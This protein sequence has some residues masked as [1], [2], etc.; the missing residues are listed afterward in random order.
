MPTTGK[1]VVRADISSRIGA[2][3]VMRCLALAQ[4]WQAEGGRTTFVCSELP[5]EFDDRL[6]PEC[7]DVVMTCARIDDEYIPG[8]E[9]PPRTIVH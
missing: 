7:C 3:H 1:L 8:A 5:G 6:R 2:G 4:Q 9:F